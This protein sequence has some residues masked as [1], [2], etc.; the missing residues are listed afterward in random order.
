M[1]EWFRTH[2]MV[3]LLLLVIAVIL[4]C[5][6][7]GGPFS[8]MRDTEFAYL[9]QPRTYT[10]VVTDYPSPRKKTYCVELNRRLLVYLDTAATM[11]SLGDTVLVKTTIRRGGVLGKFDYGRYLRMQG[12]IGSG[13]ARARDFQILHPTQ[14]LP[15]Y[16][17]PRYIQHRLYERLASLGLASRE[18][19]TLAAITLGYKEDLDPD[20]KRAFQASGAAHVL[21]VSGLHTGII[22]TILWSLLTLFGWRKPLYEERGKRIVLSVVILMCLWTY[23]LITGFTPSVVRAT[24]M[25]STAQIG[26]MCYRQ[27]NSFNTVATAAVFI[28]LFAPRSLFSASFQLSF[29]AVIAILAAVQIVRYR[30]PVTDLL[31][32]SVAAWLG[33]LP[34]TLCYFGQCSNYFLLTNCIVIVLAWL[35]VF[36]GLACMVFGTIPILG[37]ILVSCTQWIT[38]LMDSATEWIESLPGAVTHLAITPTMAVVLYGAIILFF[39]GIYMLSTR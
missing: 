35:A 22:Y 2:P 34:L 37:K 7:I 1:A 32:V 16:L 23:A 9:D 31:L 21:A 19:G 4:V 18:L 13:Y 11:P 30:H 10:A 3:V 36:G 5:N 25:A 6:Y 27:G 8:L 24:I 20:T 38:W 12:I 15:L 39:C 29:A 17:W 28:L 26:Y 14:H 33:T